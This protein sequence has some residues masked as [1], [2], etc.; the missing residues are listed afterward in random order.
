MFSAFAYYVFIYPLSLLPLRVMYLFT[1]F[2]YLLLIS[3]IPYRRSVVRGNIERSFPEKSTKEKRKIERQFYRHLTD[4]LAEGAKNLSISEK[5]LLKRFK[6]ENPEIMEEL[7]AKNKDVLLVSGHYNNW[8]WLITGQNLLFKHQ[9]VGI[10]MP[11][12]NGFWDKK[13]NARRSRFGMKVIH[14]KIVHE[15]LK[16]NSATIS[17]LILAD[18]SPGNSK[19]CYW[20]EFLNQTSGIIFG[21]EMLA[22][23]YDQAV[24]Y[25]SLHKVKR[26]HYSMQLKEITS[27]PRELEYGEITE[28]FAHLLEETINEAPQYWIWSHKRWKRDI[29]ADLKELRAQQIQKFND[30][31]RSN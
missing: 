21:P 8:E 4:L 30:R 22:N 16:S 1:D 11:L 12:S 3:V 25:F 15:F 31:F 28:R 18:Q 10:G 14:A 5:Q 24:V 19:K 26:G 27:T 17:T 13:L 29:P 23:Q 2:F 6:V 20:M 9:A 7:Y